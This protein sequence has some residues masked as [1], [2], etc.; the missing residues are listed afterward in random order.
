MVTQAACVTAQCCECSSSSSSSLCSP[1]AAYQ[2]RVPRALLLVAGRD[3][4]HTHHFAEQVLMLPLVVLLLFAGGRRQLLLLTV[5]SQR[6][7]GG[8][9]KS[10]ISLRYYQVLLIFIMY[11]FCF[12]LRPMRTRLQHVF[13]ALKSTFEIPCGLTIS[14]LNGVFKPSSKNSSP[15]K[16]Y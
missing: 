10:G 2:S 6:G 15:K 11:Q 14:P 12:E 4:L 1:V 13:K 7:E 9:A 3:A 16:I 5:N 8:G